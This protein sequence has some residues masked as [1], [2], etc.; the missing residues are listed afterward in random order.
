[1]E[2]VAS[3][4]AQNLLRRD[5]DIALRMFDPAQNALIARR[6]GDTP[7][8]L[9]GSRAFL[10]RC[11]PMRRIDEMLRHGVIVKRRPNLALTQFC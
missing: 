6:L 4:L 7:L 10:A 3:D 9:F 1:M 5:A 2:L 11:S 8:G